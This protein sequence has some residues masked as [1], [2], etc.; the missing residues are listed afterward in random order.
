MIADRKDARGRKSAQRNVS[1]TL[2]YV[3]NPKDGGRVGSIFVSDAM[4]LT[5][6]SD[7]V[8]IKDVFQAISSINLRTMNPIR[9][10]VLSWRKE[11]GSTPAERMEAA[12]YFAEKIGASNCPFVAVQHTDTEHPHVHIVISRIDILTGRMVRLGNGWDVRES[13]RIASQINQVYGWQ[14]EQRW[15]ASNDRARMTSTARAKAIATGQEA[16]ESRIERAW[17]IAKDAKT[18]QEFHATCEKWNVRYTS[19]ENGN[20]MVWEVPVPGGIEHRKASIIRNATRARLEKKWGPWEPPVPQPMMKRSAEE[21]QRSAKQKEVKAMNMDE[22]EKMLVKEQSEAQA[23][24]EQFISGIL[25]PTAAYIPMSSTPAKPKEEPR[26]PE[27]EPESELKAKANEEYEERRKRREAEWEEERKRKQHAEDVYRYACSMITGPKAKHETETEW[28]ERKQTMLEANRV[29]GAHLLYGKARSKS[30]SSAVWNAV[31]DATRILEFYRVENR[32]LYQELIGIIAHRQGKN[33]E[34]VLQKYGDGKK[35]LSILEKR[36][37]RDDPVYPIF[38]GLGYQDYYN[39]SD[40]VRC[41]DILYSWANNIDIDPAQ[42]TLH[43]WNEAASM[44]IIFRRGTQEQKKAL[45]TALQENGCSTADIAKMARWASDPD[46]HIPEPAGTA[47]MDIYVHPA[48]AEEAWGRELE[49]ALAPIPPKQPKDEQ[50]QTV[51][52]T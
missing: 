11:E 28:E 23:A 45:A 38:S 17:N 41:V 26:K 35:E 9:H 27:P 34:A 2:A 16:P 15:T 18:W 1:D 14:Q 40:R 10:F 8:M 19:A 46:S 32:E 7:T 3:L 21:I 31:A 30:C 29:L 22:Y 43:A 51:E 49:D 4:G 48:E 20:G 39:A 25:T 44:G 42:E 37:T 52:R 50:T 6:T 12:R 47:R 13:H 24:A 5:D 36:I 33:K